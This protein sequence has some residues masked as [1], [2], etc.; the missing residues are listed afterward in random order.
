MTKLTNPTPLF[1]DG[2]G[3]L[4]DG[5]FV[6]LGVAGSDPET[7]ANR[8]NIFWD[9]A[10]TIPAAQPLRTL[11]GVIVNGSNPGMIYFA[12]T[13]FSIRINDAN[14]LAVSFVSTAFDLGGVAYQSF[15]AD[16]TAIA[17]IA[18]TAY[19]RG[20]L[21]LANTAALKAATGIVDSLPLT[22]GT[23]SG[24]IIRASAGV[25][26][27]FANAAMTGARI[28]GPDATGTADATSQ[29]GDMQAYY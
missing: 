20:L 13:D 1:L 25:H 29:P 4:L 3:A 2:R 24:N 27:Y 6:Y 19:G 26:P 17:A 23:V 7:P 11:G 22:G 18:T 28:Y 9:K 21:T 5:G 12:E 14:G 10:L 15:D 16:L 8:I